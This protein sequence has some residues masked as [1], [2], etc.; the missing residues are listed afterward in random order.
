MGKTQGQ[1]RKKEKNERPVVAQ[2]SSPAIE[3]K[4]RVSSPAP[5]HPFCSSSLPFSILQLHSEE[6]D[7][8]LTQFH[9]H[10]LQI[11]PS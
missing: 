8:Y 9:I 1:E 6:K 10:D 11:G 7:W 2:S 5:A 4:R 3:N